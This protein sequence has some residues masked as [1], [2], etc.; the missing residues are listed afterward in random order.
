[1]PQLNELGT[2]RLRPGSFLSLPLDVRALT[3]EVSSYVSR[4]PRAT[5]GR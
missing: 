3:G 4:L 2:V 5:T 1:M